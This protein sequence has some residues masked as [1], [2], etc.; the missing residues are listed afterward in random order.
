MPKAVEKSASETQNLPPEDTDVP[1]SQGESASSDLEQDAEVSF[2]P[3]L[4]P[5]AH[6]VH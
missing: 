4:V 2:H 5:P 3:S 1:E 6:P